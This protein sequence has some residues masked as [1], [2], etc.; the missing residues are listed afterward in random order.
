[1]RRRIVILALFFTV[2]YSG[3]A[4]AADFVLPVAGEVEIELVGSEAAWANSLSARLVCPCDTD[5]DLLSGRTCQAGCNCDN[6]CAGAPNAFNDL[7][8]SVPNIG[9]SPG[10]PNNGCNPIEGFSAP[11]NRYLLSEKK[12][13][14]LA[15]PPDLTPTQRGCRVKLQFH[16]M[17]GTTTPIFPAGSIFRFE[18]CAKTDGVLTTCNHRWSSNP[19]LNT[20]TCIGDPCTNDGT[21]ASRQLMRFSFTAGDACVYPPG[22]QAGCQQPAGEHLLTRT[23][24]ANQS[25]RLEW[26][27]LPWGVDSD[28]ADFDD[29]IVNVHRV[30]DA[31]GTMIN[32]SDGDGLFDNWESAGGIDINNDGVLD[33]L[34]PGAHVNA[35]DV[36]V[37]LDYMSCQATN[38]SPTVGSNTYTFPNIFCKQCVTA[39]DCDHDGV[40]GV[41]GAGGY[42]VHDH[43]P[44]AT[45]ISALES[46]FLNGTDGPV[47]LHAEIGNPLP[48]T[49]WMTIK[50]TDISAGGCGDLSAFCP[51]NDPNV[52][53]TACNGSDRNCIRSFDEYK[54][55]YYGSNNPQRF[56][57]HYGI[58][59]HGLTPSKRATGCGEWPGN[60]IYISA[61]SPI[62]MASTDATTMVS[63]GSDQ[64][65]ASTIM[66]ELGHNFFLSHGGDP[67]NDIERD[68]MYK[69]NYPS[70]MNYT[71]QREGLVG[72]PGT[73]GIPVKIDY[74]SGLLPT[75]DEA[76]L[77]EMAFTFPGQTKWI[78]NSITFTTWENF[79]VVHNWDGVSN[80]PGP[81]RFNIDDDQCGQ[82]DCT[83]PNAA[84][85]WMTSVHRDFD[86]WE[87]LEFQFQAVRDFEDGVHHSG[88]PG[89]EATYEE[90]HTPVADSGA[91]PDGDPSS[92]GDFYTCDLGGAAALDGS[93]S[94]DTNPEGTIEDYQW[95]FNTPDEFGPNG[96]IASYSC[97]TRLG[98]VPIFL[99]VMDNDGYSTI[100]SASCEVDLNIG[101]DRDVECTSSLGASVTLGAGLPGAPIVYQWLDGA[102]SIGTTPQVTRTF[103][104]GTHSI[105]LN[106]HDGDGASDSD[107]LSLGVRYSWSGVLQPI[108]PDGSSL[109]KKGQVVPIR[110]QLDCSGTNISDAVVRL[111]SVT[112][113]SGTITGTE[114]ESESP[115]NANS[116]NLFD[117]TGGQYNYNL[118]TTG[119]SAG[120][121][122]IKIDLGDG[123]TRDVR[124]SVR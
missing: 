101:P 82:P 100:D 56:A 42:C 112:K 102:E 88:P 97:T 30:S 111:L 17:N 15:S 115:G 5:R 89:G 1:M 49:N 45:V 96:A 65:V 59:G 43:R 104:I 34:L 50:F 44:S 116:G 114:L 81:Y 46:A 117:Y 113:I 73:G 26:E 35:K 32:D 109:F 6:D 94:H 11:S 83:M 63:V 64:L 8:L 18:M 68:N 85:G 93:G 13:A 107:S 19:S 23:I 84:T 106:A 25:W 20:E 29:L 3:S 120:T 92:P 28:W 27:D 47:Y 87:N 7:G 70:V 37:H 4:I 2:A 10:Y 14:V 91:D 51:S 55:A 22:R 9:T 54:R 52:R 39:S 123:T 60:D 75:L 71:F 69:P 48:H 57:Y 90:L 108:N 74:S 38:T 105:T 77:A 118:S 121:W 58:I 67:R 99:T 124:F 24:V 21:G 41:C 36:Y 16:R 80:G 119:L 98:S 12:A 40:A 31:A 103:S 66:H 79:N 110:L 62:S 61:A 95:S 78:R 33:V 76:S 122:V 72:Q 53:C 86:D